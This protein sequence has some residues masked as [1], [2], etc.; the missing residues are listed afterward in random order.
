[1]SFGELKELA[2]NLLDSVDGKCTRCSLLPSVEEQKF[3]VLHVNIPDTSMVVPLSRILEN[4]FQQSS[5]LLK[6]RCGNCCSH[7]SNCPQ[8]RQCKPRESTI[9]KELVKGPD[10]L[11]IQLSRFTH[12]GGR[13]IKTTVWPDE[14]L[15]MTTGELYKLNSISHHMGETANSG[16]YLASVKADTFWLRCNDTETTQITEDDAKSSE[17]HACLYVKLIDSSTPFIP[18]EEWQNIKGRMVPG[19]LHYAFG[20]KGNYAKKLEDNHAR[21]PNSKKSEEILPNEERVKDDNNFHSKKSEERLPN[22]ERGTDKLS[23]HSKKSEERLPNEKRD[24]PSSHNTENPR[25]DIENDIKL[26][27]EVNVQRDTKSPPELLQTYTSNPENVENNFFDPGIQTRNRK[28]RKQQPMCKNCNIR[29]SDLE[30]HHKISL[31]CKQV[32]ALTSKKLKKKRPKNYNSDKSRN[33]STTEEL[34]TC[35]LKNGNITAG[36]IDDNLQNEENTSD[37]QKSSLLENESH[38]TTT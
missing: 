33:D 28:N 17:C 12:A 37:V 22:E 25:T 9:Q 18:T 21:R 31:I 19:G 16:H 20:Q 4:H 11:V 38:K 27:P 7:I 36:S 1:M 24:D 23:S 6:M 14:V 29:F 10:V 13:K 15:E 8:T 32:I 35:E 2:R 30:E 26:P 3:T 5:D 34:Q